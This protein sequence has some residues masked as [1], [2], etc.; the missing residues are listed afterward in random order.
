[1]SETSSGC[2]WPGLAEESRLLRHQSDGRS[3][4]TSSATSLSARSSRTNS[5][6]YSESCPD[7][8]QDSQ[9]TDMEHANGSI[10]TSKVEAKEASLHV[11]DHKLIQSEDGNC[12]LTTGNDENDETEN[13]AKDAEKPKIEG[14]SSLIQQL[15]EMFPDKRTLDIKR[16]LCRNRNNLEMAVLSLLEDEPGA[17][18]TSQRDF[19]R[20]N[21]ATVQFTY[22]KSGRQRKH[23]KSS[24]KKSNSQS[25]DDEAEGSV[26]LDKTTASEMK[27]FIVDK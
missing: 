24:R 2:E 13:D 17:V 20:D 11:P 21:N 4:S 12:K 15:A 22:S 9:I 1:M 23:S 8:L 19:G 18:V 26:S 5:E 3:F 7:S 16:S 10:G 27:S 25:C 14:I 6:S